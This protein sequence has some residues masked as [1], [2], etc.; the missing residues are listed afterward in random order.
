[1]TGFQIPQREQLKLDDTERELFEAFKN[2]QTAVEHGDTDGTLHFVKQ[3]AKLYAC[4]QLARVGEQYM[5]DGSFTQ[6]KKII[7]R[8]EEL[9]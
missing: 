6:G 5:R 2:V 4:T 8:A 9:K 7:E 1:M 3:Y